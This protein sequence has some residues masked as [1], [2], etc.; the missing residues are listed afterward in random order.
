MKRDRVALL[1][2]KLPEVF[3]FA[4]EGYMFLNLAACVNSKFDLSTVIVE[5]TVTCIYRHR[6]NSTGTQPEI[7]LKE[8]KRYRF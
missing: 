4:Y 6:E 7:Y 5:I 1:K 2:C 3:W 8:I